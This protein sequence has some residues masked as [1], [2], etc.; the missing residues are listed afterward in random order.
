M[1]SVRSSSQNESRT[2]SDR[3]SGANELFYDVD[4]FMC[5]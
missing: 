2:R 4:R 3:W 1:I 5:S